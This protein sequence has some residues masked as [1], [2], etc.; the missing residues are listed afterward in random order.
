M[1]APIEGS[2]SGP[3]EPPDGS[4]GGWDA[5]ELDGG[6]REAAAAIDRVE[7]RQRVKR[8]AHIQNI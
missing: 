5:I 1:A 2:A 7:H 4:D 3:L 6:R 8:H